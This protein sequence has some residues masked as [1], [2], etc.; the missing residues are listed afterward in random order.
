MKVTSRT[1]ELPMLRISAIENLTAITINIDNVSYKALLDSE[2]GTSTV[3]RRV[4]YSIK[5]KPD[6][7]DR[8]LNLQT[9]NRTN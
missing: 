5:F 3:R 8:K 9:A 1:E 7:E 6:F 4:S 2:T